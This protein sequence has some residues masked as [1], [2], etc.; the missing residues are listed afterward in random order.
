MTTPRRILLAGLFNETHTFLEEPATVEA[1]EM[2][3]GR[4]LLECRGDGSPLDGFLESAEKFGWEVVPSIDSRGMPGGI[5]PAAVVEG[6]WERFRADAL[7]AGRV[8][9]V[10]L[11]LHGAMAAVGFPDVEGEILS[12]LR[13]C[14]AMRKLRFLPSWICTRMSPR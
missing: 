12:R 8:D 4:A 14:R 13:G 5:V 9:A 11:V 10:F 1:F 2:R 3:L 7:A 6:F